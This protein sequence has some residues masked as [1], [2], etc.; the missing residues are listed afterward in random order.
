MRGAV[1]LALALGGCVAAAPD[2]RPL[3]LAESGPV[4]VTRGGQSY[5]ADL[6][7]VEGGQSL[8]VSRDG[9]G[10]GYDEGLEASRVAA[11][12]CASRDRALVPGVLGRFVGGAWL[13]DGGCA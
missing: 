1:I 6:Q 13:F 12:F 5:L 3:S 7:P 2:A 9:A 11:E 8:A 10:F 4:A